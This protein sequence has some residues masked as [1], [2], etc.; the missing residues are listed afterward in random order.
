[1]DEHEWTNAQSQTQK[2]KLPHMC[3]LKR[4]PHNFLSI[5]AL[6]ELTSAGKNRAISL[7]TETAPARE[8][9]LIIRCY[10]W[11]LTTAQAPSPLTKGLHQKKY[12]KTFLLQMPKSGAARRI[13]K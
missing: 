11:G 6:P 10:V 3:I 8:D 13:L 7:K 9:V 2:T 5:I 1:M 4:P 12:V